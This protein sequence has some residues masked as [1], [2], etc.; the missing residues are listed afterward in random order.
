MHI[1]DSAGV[2]FGRTVMKNSGVNIGLYPSGKVGKNS[3][4][5]KQLI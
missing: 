2:E 5:S 3:I 4:H 1:P